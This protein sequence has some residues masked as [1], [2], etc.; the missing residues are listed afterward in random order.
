MHRREF[1][2]KTV[3]GATAL[4]ACQLYDLAIPMGVSALST[5]G[6][7]GIEEG[8]DIL[9]RG[10]QKNTV[11]RIRQEITANP[12]AVFLIETHV[13]AKP[14]K[15]GFY[16]EAAEQLE[17]SGKETV[18][19][20]FEKGTSKGGSTLIKPNF[21]YVPPEYTNRTCGVLT[22]PD[23]IAGFVQ[24][25][26]DIENS[27]VIL[28][29]RMPNGARN[30]RQ[31]G[32]YDILDRKEIPLIEANYAEFAHHT[33]KELNWNKTRNSV[34]WKQIP[35]WR[36][37]GDKDCFL[38]NMPTMKVHTTG[39]TTLAVKNMQGS[40]TTGYG[41]LCYSWFDLPLA[42]KKWGINFK[43]DFYQDYQ[44]RVEAQ[45]V[46]HLQAGFKYWDYENS[47]KKYL[48]KGGWESF[49]KINNDEKAVND[50]AKDIGQLMRDEMW[51]QRG[52]DNADAV[53]P[54][55]NIVEGIIGMDGTQHGVGRVGKDYL[56]NII[57][58]GMSAFEVDT[59]GSYIMGHNPSEIWYTRVAK[60]RGLGECDINKVQ[61]F[62]IRD[63]NTVVP[64]K[65]LSEIKR[66]RLGVNLHTWD[67]TGKRLFW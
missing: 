52:L 28:G 14:D 49:R 53:R 63:D 42:A 25:L 11:P 47:Y 50:F 21:T 18:K 9:E 64:V 12:R 19:K 61:I 10:K 37:V 15:G 13:N 62:K 43:G 57:I 56:C 66:Y 36:P 8:L 32:I 29:E 26:R 59:V 44:Q 31:A 5:S 6:G 46:K 48:E 17:I 23:F 4:A 54:N 67:E 39:L 16:T 2:K 3:T 35:H 20:L 65:D 30:H 51:L 33:P 45:F 7:I 27:N 22:K 34:V 55:I 40:V 1:I 41:Y 38:I 24:G 58:A 60:E